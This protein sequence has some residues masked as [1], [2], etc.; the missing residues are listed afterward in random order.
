MKILGVTGTRADWGLL[1]PVFA[2]LR[3]DPQ[4]EFRLVVTGQ[5]LTV[6]VASLAAIEADG[7]FVDHR[8][9][10][11]LG[12]D[13]SAAALAA[14]SGRALDGMG[15]VLAAEDPDLVLV[16]GDRYE[17][18][19]VVFAA[20][21]ARVPVAHLCGGDVTEGAMDDSIRHAITKM[22]S[23]HFPSNAEARA[24][25]LQMGE[26]PANVHL[27]GSTGLDRVRAVQPLGRAEF[28]QA[29]GLPDGAQTLLVTVH[30][31]TLAEDPIL[32][33]LA[34]LS[35]LRRLPDVS[36]LVT[37]SNADPGGAEID[38]LMRD[39]VAERA[40][41]AFFASLGSLRYF[42]ALTHCDAVVGNSSSGLY[43]APSFA[44]PTVNIGTRQD[45]RPRAASVLDCPSEAD[46]ILAAIGG[47]LSR[48]RVSVENPYGDGH[49][50]PRIVEVLRGVH[51]PAR[52]VRKAFRDAV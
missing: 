21:L 14:A 48:G 49:S 29:V 16:L 6:D 39:F 36:V 37:G 4:F 28:F 34:L 35:A 27:V 42:S 8:V 31:A 7:F 3:D 25:I 10:M 15:Q 43:E 30:P 23:L 41:A 13:D 32:E 47:A 40:N 38:G 45:G 11:G 50:A 33:C 2:L 1:A 24:R 51:D 20:V 19:A 52:L 17:I 26:D 5:H 12:P 18:L 9:E 22:V 46:A 44:I